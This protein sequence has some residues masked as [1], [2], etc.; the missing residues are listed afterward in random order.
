MIKLLQV[1]P[2]PNV[3]L[4]GLMVKKEIELYRNGKGTFYRSATKERDRAKWSHTTYKG[5]IKMERCEGEVVAAEIRSLSKGRDEWQL[6][7]AFIG[8]LDRHFGENIEA[9]HIHYRSTTTKRR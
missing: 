5:W 4:F 8:W 7:H 1:V 9:I 3:R 6:L 2:R